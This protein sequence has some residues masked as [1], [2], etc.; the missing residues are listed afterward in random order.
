[1]QLSLNEIELINNCKKG[2]RKAQNLLFDHY[3][4]ALYAVCMRYMGDRDLANDVFQD[5]MIKIYKSLDQFSG[6]GKFAAWMYRIMANKSLDALRK[7]TR[8]VLLHSI[9]DTVKDEETE[10]AISKMNVEDIHHIITKL[11]EGYRTIFNLYIIEGY[12]HSEISKM[13]SISEGTSKSQLSRARAMLKSL[14][15]K[16]NQELNYETGINQA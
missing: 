4:S 11:P 7:K 1:M 9:E 3:G 14:L 10:S 6:N 12:N 2:D 5:G 8:M 13:L 15:I 16:E